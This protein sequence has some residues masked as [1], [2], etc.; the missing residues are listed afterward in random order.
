MS[1]LGFAPW[2]DGRGRG[3]LVVSVGRS[4]PRQT[5]WLA[6]YEGMIGV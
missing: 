1:A 4:V 2:L 6:G 3:R 5:L